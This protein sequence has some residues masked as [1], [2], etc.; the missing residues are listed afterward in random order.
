MKS[1]DF[2]PRS[3]KVLTEAVDPA[4]PG[5]MYPVQAG[6]TL[7][8]LAQAADTTV[9][10]LL[11]MNPDIPATGQITVG[12]KIKLPNLGEFAGVQ[13]TVPATA[14]GSSANAAT[15]LKFFTQQGWS[16][17]QAAGIVGNL[18]AES[19]PN[20]NPAALGDNGQAYGIAQ[21]R[22]SRQN[23]FARVM[24][25]PLK[26]S[27]LQDQLEFMQWEL[28]NTEKAAGAKLKSAKSA[29]EAAEIFD[30]FYERS[31]GLHTDRRVANA[32][33]LAPS[34]TAVT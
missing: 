1:C 7:E 33:A 10:G 12:N 14:A 6:D 24:G 19:T 18:Q 23:D 2:L 25:K 29:A 16:A 9:S 3:G 28:N 34:D 26:G 13:T 15:A 30:K 31:A 32:V 27:G 22:G 20:I 11:Y 4:I 8:K 17:A 21:W 5:K